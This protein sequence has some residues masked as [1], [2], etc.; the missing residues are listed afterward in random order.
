MCAQCGACAKVYLRQRA[1]KMD[2]LLQKVAF[3]ILEV[4]F[5]VEAAS[6]DVQENCLFARERERRLKRH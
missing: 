2:E 3:L 1:S 6:K 4:S 5:V